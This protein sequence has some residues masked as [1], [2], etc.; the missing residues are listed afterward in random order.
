[1]DISATGLHAQRVRMDVI[2]NNIANASTTRTEEG[3]PYK[4]QE[5]IFKS[6]SNAENPKK[7]GVEIDTIVESTDPPKKVYDPS[8]PDAGEDGMVAFPNINVIEEMVDMISATRAYE[9]NIQAV[10]AAKMMAKKAL[11]IGR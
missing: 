3:G 8:N 9:A 2:A 1:M 4:K 5:V 6:L 11:E 10:G 7:G